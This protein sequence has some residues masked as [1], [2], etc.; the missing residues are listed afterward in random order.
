[1]AQFTRVNGDYKPLINYDAPAYQNSGVNAVVSAATVQP[2]GP[3]LQFLTITGTGT[4]STTQVKTIFQTVEQLSS[5]YLYEYTSSS[6]DTLAL[7]LYPVN[8]WDLTA[9]DTALTAAGVTGTT[10]TATATF[11]N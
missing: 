6:N 7:A 9:L 5:V 1:M 8:G 2:Q 3:K 11:T 10:S 4:F